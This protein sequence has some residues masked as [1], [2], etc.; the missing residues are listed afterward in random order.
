MFPS[1]TYIQRAIDLTCLA[2]LVILLCFG[3]VARAA[4]P[5]KVGMSMAL[6][7]PLAGTGKAALLG[8]QIWIEDINTQGG[9]LGRPVQLIYYDDQSNPSLVPG[10]YTN[11]S[12]STKSISRRQAMPPTW[13][14]PPC[15]S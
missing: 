11:S 15:P 5:I 4:E 13:W 3:V 2:L 6:T 12:M 10:I 1:G 14:R 7:G 8:T 9:I